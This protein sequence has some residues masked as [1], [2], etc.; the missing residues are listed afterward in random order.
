MEKAL[1]QD[2]SG[3]SD[4]QE[5]TTSIKSEINNKKMIKHIKL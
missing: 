5:S 2:I 4:G 1:K 3:S